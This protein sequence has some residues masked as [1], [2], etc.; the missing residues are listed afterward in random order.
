M[1]LSTII[2]QF[3]DS[4]RHRYA[5]NLLPGHTKALESMAGCRHE[6]GPHMLAQCAN[7]QCDTTA[8]IPHSCGHRNCPHC[9]NHESQQW[10]EQQLSKR[11]PCQYYL[12]T[13][14][15]PEQ[16]RDLAWKNQKTVYSLMFATVQDLLKSFTKHDK[17]LGGAPG[18]TAVLHT[19]TRSLDYH[20]HIHVVMPG[21]SI[22]MQTSLWRVKS[23]GYLFSHK[24]LAKVFRARLLQALK[25]NKLPIPHD[26]PKQWVVDCKEAGNGDQALVYLGRYLYRG[27]IREKDILH[28]RDGMV[29]FRYRHAKS[30]EDRTRTVTGEYFLYLLMLHVLPRGFR[31][32]RSY[33]FLHSCSK[34]LILFLQMVLR[35]V[36]WRSLAR[37]LKQR[38]AIICPAC[39]AAMVIVATML[40]HRHRPVRP[41]CTGRAA[42]GL[43]M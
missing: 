22:N 9:Q 19:Q 26:C 34:K 3:A 17:K 5:K 4:F 41:D 12:I 2:K 1:L 25:E 23:P 42:E 16:L 13:F 40:F 8:Y 43:S 35:V 36:P 29:T 27:V 38:P 10:I 21:A 15:L 31:R 24:A 20:P 37:N 32:A 14:T 18:F 11:L 28:C 7:H 30:G 6:H 33:G 39:G